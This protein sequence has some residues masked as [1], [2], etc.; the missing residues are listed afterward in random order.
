ML[1]I[2]K[3]DNL[4]DIKI[5]VKYILIIFPKL[6]ENELRN[7]LLTTLFYNYIMIRENS[8]D[9][10]NQQDYN[11][12]LGKRDF[13]SLTMLNKNLNAYDNRTN[14]T[15]L[16]K[17]DENIN[18][19][20]IFLINKFNKVGC[21]KVQFKYLLDVHKINYLFISDEY[22]FISKYIY[23][24]YFLKINLMNIQ[25]KSMIEN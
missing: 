3:D 1:L 25:L 21:S 23:M 16:L 10:Y 6:K 11:I 4:Y 13:V 2:F 14:N 17:I 20:Y 24:I 15:F 12:I 7:K 5:L 22:N 19:I 9:I 18:E 8:I